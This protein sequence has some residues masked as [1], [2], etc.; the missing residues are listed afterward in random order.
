MAVRSAYDDSFFKETWLIMLGTFLLSIIGGL[1]GGAAPALVLLWAPLAYH[2]LFR[3]PVH[4]GARV[5]LVLGLFIEP[6]EMM[7]GARYWTS[8]LDSANHALYARLK[9]LTGIPGLSFPLFLVAI[10]VLL[11][12][13]RKQEGPTL[14]TPSAR[15][16]RNVLSTVIFAILAVEAYGIVR[17]GRVEPSFN[18][19]LEIFMMPLAGLLFFY[20]LRGKQ[21]LYAIGNIIVSVAIARSL[22]V[23]WVY[24]VVCRPMGIVPEYATTHGDST[25]F[26]AAFLILLAN[27]I[28]QRNARTLGRFAFASFVLLA[29]MA[30][31]N[32]R[33]VF[34]A[35]GAGAV[36]MYVS[37][38]PSQIRRRVNKYLWIMGPLLALY[39]FI[40]EGSKHPFFSP[41]KLVWSALE[42]KDSSSGSRVIENTNLIATYSDSPVLGQGFGF[43]YKEVVRSV[44]L[45]EFM[46][47]YKFIP[48]NSVLWL[49]SAG[50]IIGFVFLW[51]GYV[52]A[53][54][55][56]A[57]AHRLAEGPIE[58]A[59][60]LAAVGMVAVCM[61]T[62]WGD[63]GAKSDMKVLVFGVAFG[64]GARLCAEWENRERGLA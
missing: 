61:M 64:V 23:A 50:G 1:L 7:P 41:A 33:L 31:N 5:L 21:D 25:T 15:I 13:A 35:I 62:D 17:G 34:M 10:I 57:R 16:A 51:L 28:E 63:V 60:T 27:I 56:A 29:A 3:A 26:A 40:G 44:D 54:F 22:L 20:A 42:Q 32:R 38:P 24:W 48:H 49:W 59:G 58:R 18:Q 14:R 39:L 52:G 2:Y 6:P 8:P 12:R 11:Y 46:P 47:L 4:I 43:P 55:F 30:M 19:I 36:A 9:E 45:T 53:T 37:L